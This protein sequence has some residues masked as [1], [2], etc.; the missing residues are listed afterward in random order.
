MFSFIVHCFFLLLT[1]STI[2]T[3]NSAIVDLSL[4][5]QPSKN[6]NTSDGAR[7]LLN[8]TKSRYSKNVTS[9]IVLENGRKVVEYYN[10]E[11][12]VN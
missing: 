8:Y 5:L 1:A 11:K 3:G 2:T 10:W 12:E 7:S 4:A 9:Y 6:F